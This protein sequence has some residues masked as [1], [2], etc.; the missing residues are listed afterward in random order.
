MGQPRPPSQDRP[1]CRGFG[2][3][4]ALAPLEPTRSRYR[5]LRPWRGSPACR[6]GPAAPAHA[7]QHPRLRRRATATGSARH[8]RHRPRA[9]RRR[10]RHSVRRALWPHVAPAL[11]PMAHRSTPRIAAPP[12]ALRALRHRLRI[13]GGRHLQPALHERDHPRRSPCRDHADP[14]SPNVT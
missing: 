8:R 6:L 13:S 5:P 11:P 14:Q 4:Q 10:C 12:I 2:P 3:R 1:L 9:S 7:A